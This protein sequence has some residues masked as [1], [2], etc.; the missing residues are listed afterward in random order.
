[1]GAQ[2]AKRRTHSVED[3]WDREDAYDEAEYDEELEDYADMDDEDEELLPGLRLEEEPSSDELS[4]IE[5]EFSE[6][7][8]LKDLVDD[9]VRMYLREIGQVDLVKPH[10]EEWL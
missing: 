1:M 8:I 9:P 7:S 2:R 5:E 3:D 4:Q 6:P 10:Q